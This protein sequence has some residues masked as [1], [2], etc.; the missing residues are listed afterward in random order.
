[1][2][3]AK[4]ESVGNTF[5]ASYMYM[6]MIEHILVHVQCNCKFNIYTYTIIV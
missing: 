3:I 6:Y 2:V 5:H 4:S 1:M